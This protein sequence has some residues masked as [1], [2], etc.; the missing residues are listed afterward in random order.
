VNTTK[1]L[2]RNRN[3][4]GCILSDTEDIAIVVS[5]IYTRVFS[6]LYRTDKIRLTIHSLINSSYNFL[7]FLAN[8]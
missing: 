8:N 4:T 2:E 1:A 5:A 3:L 6:S 7:A